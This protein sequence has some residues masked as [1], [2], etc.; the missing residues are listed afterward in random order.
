MQSDKFSNARTE[1]N[2]ESTTITMTF[3]S[4]RSASNSFLLCQLGQGLHISQYYIY[5]YM[6]VH[7]ST[8]ADRDSLEQKILKS[9]G[10]L[11]SIDFLR[12]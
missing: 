10:R 9:Q 6:A 11:K 12:H 4:T 7:M 8:S 2:E 3:P 5:A 1:N